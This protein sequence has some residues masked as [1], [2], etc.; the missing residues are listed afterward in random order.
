MAFAYDLKTDIRYLEGREE[1]IEEGIEKG[2]EKGREDTIYTSVLNMYESRVDFIT[3]AK[4]MN[5]TEQ[6]VIEII[7]KQAKK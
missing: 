7:N 2:I 4:F 3:I 5:I 1:G 6:K